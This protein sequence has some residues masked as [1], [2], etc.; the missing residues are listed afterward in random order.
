MDYIVRVIQA[1]MRNQ[2]FMSSLTRDPDRIRRCHPGQGFATEFTVTRSMLD[3]FVIIEAMAAQL[4]H[5]ADDVIDACHLIFRRTLRW[6]DL[7]G[8]P[9]LV[10]GPGSV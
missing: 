4:L 1:F 2:Q 7:I 8:V 5:V 6:A 3:A 10:T 9:V